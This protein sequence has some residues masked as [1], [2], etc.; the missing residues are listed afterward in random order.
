MDSFWTAPSP[1]PKIIAETSLYLVA[2]KPPRIHTAPLIPGEG[3][4]LLDWAGRIYP[5]VLAPLGRISREGGLLH[6]LDYETHGLVLLARTPAAMGALLDQQKQDRIVKEYLAAS[7]GVGRIVP[8]FPPFPRTR[9]EERTVVSAF[10]PYG[11][12][13]REVRPVLPGPGRTMYQTGV[14]SCGENNRKPGAPRD[15]ELRQ[16]RE[17]REPPQEENCLFRLRISRGYRHQIRCHLA[18][19]GWPIINDGLYGGKSDGGFLGLMAAA[20]EFTDPGTGERRRYD[21]SS[22]MFR[23]S[24]AR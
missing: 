20:L 11:R 24:P 14:V 18:W 15:G 1:E 23:S 9:A 3:G 17:F 13:R 10:R 19:A 12:G 8:G 21:G 6:R 5:E 16:N 2:Y 4:T 22:G 7:A